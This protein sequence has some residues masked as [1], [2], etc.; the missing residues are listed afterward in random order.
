MTE[1]APGV[2]PV[3]S[4]RPALDLAAAARQP[5]DAVLH[6]L[7]STQTGLTS[8]QAA[9]WLATVGRN[10]LASHKVTAL[11]VLGRQLR[12]PLLILLL[13]AAGVSA[14]TGDPTDG[15]IIAAIVVLSVGL[16]FVNE[17]RSEV[18]VAALHANIRHEALVWRDGR[19]QRLDVRDLVPGDV[20]AL[21]VGDLVPADLRL[22]EADQLECDEAVL[23]GEPMPAVKSAATV[24]V[25]DSAVDLPA[26]AF[27][28]T[29]VHQGAGRGVVVA[30][31]SATAFGK[32]AVGLAERQAETTFQAGLRGFSKLLVRIAAV[33]TTS[34]FVINVAFHRPLLDALLFSLAIAIGIT[35][36]LLPAIVSVSL[37]TGSRELARRRVLVK[38]LVTI[39]DLGNIEVLFT[40]KTGTLTEG[41]ITF[42]QALDPGGLPATWPLLLGLVCNEATMTANGPVGG[43]A[44]DVAL[45]SAPAAG[46]LAADA[47]GGPL[48]YQRLGLAPFDHDRQL[49]SVTVRTSAGATLLVVKGAP[50]AVL[51]RCVDVPADAPKSLER[52]FADGARVVA[53]ATRDAPGLTTPGPADEHDLH[54]VG[55]L[56]FVDRPKSDAGA[57]IAKLNGL[58]VAV[59]V[60]TG[61]NPIVAAKVCRDLG[62][63]LEQVRTGAELE[64]LDDEALAAA[65]PHTTVFARVSPDQKSRIIKVARRTGVDVAFLGD[66]V[67]DAVALHAADVGISVESATDVAKDAADIVL[68]DKDLGVLADGVTEG[69]RIF[70]NTLKYVLMATSS[71][72]GNMVSAAGASLFLSFLP[73]LPS[74]ILLNNLLYDAGQLAIPTDRVDPEVLAR[75]AAWDIGFVRRFMS[76]FGPVSSIFDFLTFFVMLRVL[77]AS[78][79]EFRSGWFVESLATQT[80][81]VYVIRTRRVPFFRSRPSLP[82][83]I[84]P[85]TCALVGAV[86]P[87]TPLAGF[88]GF[89]TLPISFFLILLGMIATYLLLVEIVKRRFYAV[90]ARPH[91]PP[92]IHQERRQRRI[93]RRAARFTHRATHNR[94]R[95]RPGLGPA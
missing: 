5:V 43:N 80:L 24:P 37:S 4:A 64:R 76:V 9:R 35:P 69:R 73:M 52:L 91:R 56:T 31:G 55:F 62:L 16:G 57:S 23:T 66:G 38:R 6:E 26:C 77:H 22:L 44:L 29:V 17:Y 51:A 36:Q 27:M 58:G 94:P 82:M 10:V 87:F 63:D 45:W 59:K 85:M 67:N 50:E 30:T 18:A 3:R 60:I 72:F 86:L 8:D 48:A 42:D 74:Q 75:P 70:A 12:N 21:G 7:G 2:S 54:L 83:F 49:A 92:A 90:Q 46:A 84:T 39:E 20:V 88:L 28:G 93:Q 78:H 11:G 14:A 61:D 47:T 95:R 68:L 13:A 79:S 15:A 19:Q 41:A 34:I 71:N 89:A 81:V 33:L 53:V 25:G 65:I 32:I 1:A 40:D